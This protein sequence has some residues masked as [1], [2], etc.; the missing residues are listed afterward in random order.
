MPISSKTSTPS[1]SPEAALQA[2]QTQGEAVREEWLVLLAE[3]Y[4]ANEQWDE[5]LAMHDRLEREYPV[6]RDRPSAW[7]PDTTTLQA[8]EAQTRALAN[9]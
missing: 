2:A 7:L 6:R 4:G 1:M 8:L 9:P 3:L 5:S